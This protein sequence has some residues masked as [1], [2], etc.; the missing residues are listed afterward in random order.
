M[1]SEDIHVEKSNDSNCEN[2]EQHQCN[3]QKNEPE[4][5]GATNHEDWAKYAIMN[6]IKDVI[7]S[8]ESLVDYVWFVF[9]FIF[10][11]TKNLVA[12]EWSLGSH[13]SKSN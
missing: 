10:T 7:E 4:C 6:H 5:N 1:A 13:P 12:S 9:A 11:H 2:N 8:L 3:Q